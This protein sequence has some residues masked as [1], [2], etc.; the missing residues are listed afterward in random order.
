[1]YGIPTVAEMES[2]LARLNEPM[3]RLQ[4]VEVMLRGIEEVQMFLLAHR[5]GDKAMSEPTLILNALI[6]INGTGGLYSRAVGR[7]NAKLLADRSSWTGFRTHMIAEYEKLVAEGGGTV[8]S[9]EGYGTAF[10]ATEAEDSALTES[11]T[12]Y[13]ERATTSEGDIGEL[14]G[15]MQ[16]MQMEMAALTAQGTFQ[17]VQPAY[18]PIQDYPQANY[19]APQMQTQRVPAPPPGFFNPGPNPIQMAQQ[20]QQQQQQQTS[21]KRSRRGGGGGGGGG[22]GERNFQGYGFG[23]SPNVAYAPAYAPAQGGQRERYVA[24]GS[25]AKGPAQPT[26]T[27]GWKTFQNLMYCFSCGYDVDHDGFNCPLECRKEGH[28]PN[29]PRDQAHMVQ[30]ACM[31]AQHKTL[32]DGTGA[33]KGW[34]LAGPISKAQF[35]MNR[36][37]GGRGQQ[38]QTGQGGGR[39]FG[40]G[41]GR[42]RGRSQRKAYGTD[43]YCYSTGQQWY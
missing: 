37:G 19:F 31:K 35:T 21:N 30:Y 2:N 3:D 25:N 4:P 36:M 33:G 13:A 11:L 7:W 20:Q 10:H 39:G 17:P 29:V 34:I 26:H 16:S 43:Q 24:N 41:G 15:M 40:R 9:A 22:G 18:D 14:R 1:L 8:M 38:Q 27:N 5:D 6:K 42:G 28:I 12:R 32:P 23:T